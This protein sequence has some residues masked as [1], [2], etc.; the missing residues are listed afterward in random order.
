MSK[1][2]RDKAENIADLH[3]HPSETEKLGYGILSEFDRN[4]YD[5]TKAKNDY[6]E[7]AFDGKRTMEGANGEILHKSHSAAQKK[8]GP[9]AP[10][11]QAEVDHIDPLA[12]IHSR[13]KKDLFLT[14]QDI[15]EVGNRESN[16]QILSKSDNASKG[17]R[18]E[19][20]LAL[21]PN[22]EL[23]SLE[24]AE[25]LIKGVGNRTETD[26]LLLSRQG[27]NAA[28][29]FAQGAGE[30]LSASVIPLVVRGVEDLVKVANNEMTISEATED[31]GKIGLSIAASGGT[32][33][34]V[35]YALGEVLENCENEFVKRFANANQIGT[36]LVVSSIVVR[37]AGKYLKG[38]VDGKGF[39][40]E[41]GKDGISMVGGM[42]ASEAVTALLGEL[43]GAS[44]I[45]MAAPVLAAMIA[46]AVC[47]EIYAQI[48]KLEDEKKANTEIRMIASQASNSI[49]E[50]QEKL[51]DL[52]EQQHNEWVNSMVET[53]QMIADGMTS[54]DISKTNK[55]LQQLLL[56]SR[57]SISLY[58]TGEQAIDDLMEMRAGR[59]KNG[60]L[61]R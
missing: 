23:S 3:C 10:V 58:Q 50:Q 45:T 29:E 39:F 21:D 20:D 25:K 43:V 14:D 56:H 40:A 28:K 53:F 41:V 36:I 9:R 44:F 7:K 46:S 59:M 6:R 17:K 2:V 22:R 13:H 49:N 18:S 19:I 54:S 61:T 1:D 60:L 35:T 57:R 12:N 24:R 4:Q 38:E 32:A 55:G 47:S 5:S 26:I 11:H 30:A 31:V 51:R 48:K 42:F 37:A 16:F 34:I 33:R 27:K 52:F 8:Y 15:R